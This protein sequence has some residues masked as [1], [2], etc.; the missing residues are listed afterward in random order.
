MFMGKYNA[1]STVLKMY[2]TSNHFHGVSIVFVNMQNFTLEVYFFCSIILTYFYP[3][4]SPYYFLVESKLFY[5]FTVKIQPYNWFFSS[6]WQL[7]YSIFTMRNCWI[8]I[9]LFIVKE[10]FNCCKYFI[11]LLLI[12]IDLYIVNLFET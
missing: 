4:P 7:F 11:F 1:E 2:L 10:S 9:V 3:L 12:E 8:C 5:C 6:F